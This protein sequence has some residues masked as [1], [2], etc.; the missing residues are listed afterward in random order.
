[1]GEGSRGPSSRSDG[2]LMKRLLEFIP[3]NRGTSPQGGAIMPPCAAVMLMVAFWFQQAR[4]ATEAGSAC[5]SALGERWT[6]AYLVAAFGVFAC[7]GYSHRHA[8]RWP[9]PHPQPRLGDMA[10]SK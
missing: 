6:K 10:R 8:A 2:G 3:P 9:K 4:N 5:R 1:M 7:Q